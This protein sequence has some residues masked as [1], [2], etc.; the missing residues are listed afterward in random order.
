M[1]S[2]SRSATIAVC[3]GLA[4]S[5]AL[6]GCESDRNVV[7]PIAPEAMDAVIEEVFHAVLAGPSGMVVEGEVLAYPGGPP[8]EPRYVG[9][10]PEIS[11][12]VSALGDTEISAD[13]DRDARE[14]LAR[15]AEKWNGPGAPKLECFGWRGCGVSG[16]GNQVL[17][18]TRAERVSPDEMVLGVRH[19]T[20]NGLVDGAFWSYRVYEIPLEWTGARFG[21]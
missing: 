4:C 6:A 18:I 12:V 17:A 2:L 14:A 16:D 15:V 11:A 9:V 8:A 7:D 1:K 20:G 3:V 21:R 10:D 19:A 5:V 13:S